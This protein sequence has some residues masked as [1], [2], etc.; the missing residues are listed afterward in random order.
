MAYVS[1]E[2]LISPQNQ[3]LWFLNAA[4]FS[5]SFSQS[6]KLMHP[7]NKYNILILSLQNRN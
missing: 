4:E 3:H 6:P 1:T 5:Q 2:F 7:R